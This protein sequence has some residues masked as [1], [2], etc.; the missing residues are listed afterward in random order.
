MANLA[1]SGRRSAAS[2]T[3]KS[4]GF[5]VLGAM[6]TGLFLAKG[7]E[8]AFLRNEIGSKSEIT[9]RSRGVEASGPPLPLRSGF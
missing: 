6:E 8:K 5:R 1:G 9:L 7:E 4:N 2:V 3:R